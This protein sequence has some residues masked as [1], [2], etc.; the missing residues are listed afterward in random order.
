MGIGVTMD[1]ARELSEVLRTL[2]KEHDI[3]EIGK[4]R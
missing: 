3:V 1:P 2:A 4:E